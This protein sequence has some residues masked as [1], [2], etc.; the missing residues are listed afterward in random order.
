MLRFTVQKICALTRIMRKTPQVPRPYCPVYEP[1]VNISAFP[2]E[3]SETHAIMIT[4]I[5]GSREKNLALD[6]F[7]S[8]TATTWFAGIDQLPEGIATQ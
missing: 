7:V 8:G 1:N 2:G 5:Q 6:T 3:H 4:Y